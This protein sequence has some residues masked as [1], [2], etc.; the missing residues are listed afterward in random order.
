M[1]ENNSHLN[2]LSFNANQ[3]H[4]DLLYSSND[5]IN[6]ATSIILDEILVY[7][8]NIYN[9]IDTEKQNL[10]TNPLNK[11]GS[12]LGINGNINEKE[13]IRK[14]SC[15]VNLFE[16]E[17]TT[18][19]QKK[20][21]SDLQRNDSEFTRETRS[22]NFPDEEIENPR[23][24]NERIKNCIVTDEY[25]YIG[26]T[27]NLNGGLIRDGFG[28]C[29]YNDGKTYIGEWVSG[30][31]EGLGKILYANGDLEQGEFLNN[32]PNGY[33]EV[34]EKNK[35]IT[36]GFVNDLK[37]NDY[38][39]IERSCIT[40]EGEPQKDEKSK[41]SFGKLTYNKKGESKKVFIGNIYNYQNE[42][43][44][45][46]FYK[47]N[48]IFYC[49]IRNKKMIN[50]IENYGNESGC[51]LGFTKDNKKDNLG[52]YFIKD[53]RICIGEFEDDLKKGPVFYFQNLPK[54][55]VKMELYLMGFKTK[56]VEKMDVIRK[57]LQ[58]F[59][60]EYCQ[61]LKIDFQKFLDKISP[62]VNQ[63]I[64]NSAK[65]IESFKNGDTF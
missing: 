60:P 57:Y 56:T 38:L 11:F 14:A 52:I 6:P 29:D 20:T 31:W 9:Q 36:K 7:E 59:Y 64:T 13:K 63:E 15:D 5:N 61:V 49:E 42:N 26:E 1:E 19:D 47:E 21:E 54:P 51:F 16:P 25:K 12:V 50:Y 24:E 2:S 30:T 44:F 58:T 48:N 55:S 46:M 22:S 27:L 35:S 65:M 45:G 39:S 40:Y 10:Q 3:N 53:G 62:E 33:F 18:E 37:F 32:K 4:I 34:I 43:G 17:K 41:M 28:I 8:E 23:N